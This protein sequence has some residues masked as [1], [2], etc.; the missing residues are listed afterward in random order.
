MR[1]TSNTLFS[2]A[3]I[4]SGTAVTII[5]FTVTAFGQSLSVPNTSNSLPTGSPVQ[6][7]DCT[8][9]GEGGS[10]LTASNGRFRIVFTNEG[11]VRADLLKFRIN[12]G[13]EN[14]L[15]RDKGSFA[16]GVTVTH[17]FRSRGGTVYSSPLFSPAKVSCTVE[18]AHFVDGSEWTPS[19]AVSNTTALP[20]AGKGY[21]GISF[22]QTASGVFISLLVP[23]GA[24]RKAGLRQGDL[25]STI[26]EQ[27]V[28]TVAEALQLI[29]G[30]EPGASLKMSV[31]RDGTTLEI[32]ATVGKRPSTAP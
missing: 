6:I 28:S 7:E 10:L 4:V 18:A 1:A 8:T 31:V 25:I 19:V 15:I 20:P 16:P 2:F 30:S 22:A 14:F 9:G 27:H 23:S 13:S 24:G 26:D 29:S 12:Y 5:S 32:V 11:V 21:L 17:V 3:R